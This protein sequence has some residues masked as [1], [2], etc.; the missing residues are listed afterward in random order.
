MVANRDY[1]MIV[2]GSTAGAAGTYGLTLTDVGPVGNI[3]CGATTAEAA[4]P[5]AFLD[6]SVTDSNSN[7]QNIA[8]DMGGSLDALYQLVDLTGATCAGAGCIVGCS[9]K[10]V[11]NNITAALDAGTYRLKIKG[12]SIAAGAGDQPFNVSIR[13]ADRT[14]ALEC[15][16]GTMASAALLD[17]TQ[18]SGKRLPA[19]TYRVG[20][21]G[22]GS[23]NG[24]YKL[25]FRDPSTNPVGATQ[26]A[27]ASDAVQGAVVAG[28]PY[29]VVVKGAATAQQGTYGLTVTDMGTVRRAIRS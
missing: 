10:A 3:T 1:Y 22:Q 28:R 11:S 16:Q 21:T 13:D 14:G 7:G 2:K 25:L 12:K 29:Y 19:G 6:F 18:A 23:A 24:A 17:L 20:I 15:D 27:C 4:A 9:D 26:M 5:D 8:I